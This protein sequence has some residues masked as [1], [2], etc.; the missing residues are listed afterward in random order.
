MR[1][2]SEFREGRH[3]RV[4]NKGQS[5][6][7][8]PRTRNRKAEAETQRPA[9][10][11]SGRATDARGKKRSEQS[12]GP[13]PAVRLARAGSAGWQQ[14]VHLRGMGGGAAEGRRGEENPRNPPGP[15][16]QAP[17]NTPRGWTPTNSWSVPSSSASRAVGRVKHTIIFCVLLYW[18]FRVR[19]QGGAHQASHCGSAGEAHV[20]SGLSRDKPGKARPQAPR[21]WRAS[22][23]AAGYLR[24]LDQ[25]RSCISHG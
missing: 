1:G 18:W 17:K 13:R 3:T 7:R 22:L 8:G 24:D 14:G 6:S 19:L 10:D 16:Q 4:G 11:M 21:T 2:Q 25:T 12:I 15:H 9:G 20:Q 5:Q 23:A